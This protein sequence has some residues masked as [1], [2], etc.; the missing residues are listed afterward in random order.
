MLIY[1]YL[2]NGH[3]KGY[4][5]GVV[6]LCFVDAIFLIVRPEHL[7]GSVVIALTC[8]CF[9]VQPLGAH[10]AYY[11]YQSLQTNLTFEKLGG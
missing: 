8:C 2:K 4:E 11:F 6:I 9:A 5:V 7:S 1:L 3:E 10:H